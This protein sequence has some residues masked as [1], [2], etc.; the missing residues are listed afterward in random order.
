[1][2]N[3]IVNKNNLIKIIVITSLYYVPFSH[4]YF[5]RGMEKMIKI[6]IYK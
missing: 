6:L 1:M 5:K 2:Y 3:R 4:L